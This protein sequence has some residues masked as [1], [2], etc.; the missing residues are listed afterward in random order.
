MPR[1]ARKDDTG[2]WIDVYDAAEDS[3]VAERLGL[4]VSL[5]FEVDGTCKHGDFVGPGDTV[6]PRSSVTEPQTN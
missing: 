4:E 5:F 1:F 6:I 2:Y 3:A